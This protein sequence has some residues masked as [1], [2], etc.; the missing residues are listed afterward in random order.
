MIKL[1]AQ[2]L[3]GV[4]IIK[5]DFHPQSEQFSKLGRA[6]TAFVQCAEE[7]FSDFDGE[8]TIGWKERSEPVPVAIE[9][10]K[11]PIAEYKNVQLH[12]ELVLPA[13]Q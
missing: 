7:T 2:E 12:Q 1:E 11:K 13:E 5:L 9:E 3:R 8:M 10:T 6:L 4:P